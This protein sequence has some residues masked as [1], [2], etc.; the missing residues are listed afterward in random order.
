MSQG[1]LHLTT[2][3]QGGAGRAITALACAQQR[4]GRP[5]TVVTSR[6]GV[7][8]YGNYSEYLDGLIA[9]GVTL[10]CCDSLFNRDEP[11]NRRVLSFLLERLPLD[12]L[13]VIHAHAATP[14]TIGRWLAAASPRPIPVVQTQHG[15]G[16]SKSPEQASADIVILGTL[17]RIVATSN[18]TRDLLVSFGIKSRTIEVIPC[19]LPS[20]AAA[21]CP[22]EALQLVA[23]LRRG[24]GAV[25]GCIGSVTENKNQRLV[26]D[27]LCRLPDLDVAAVFIGEGGSALA[28]HANQAG[29][30]HRVHALGYRPDASRW[31]P[32]FDLLV[33]PSRSEGQGLVVLEAFRA[34]VP[35]VASDIPPLAQV[36]AH[37][38]NGFLFQP[39][40][41]EA[42]AAAIR[43]VL[44]LSTAGR[45]VI[46]TRAR[47]TF[48]RDYTLDRMIARHD[49][50]YRRVRAAVAPPFRP[51][52]DRG[53]PGT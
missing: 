4:S 20:A 16:T 28:D 26:V 51:G 32:S 5:V 14:A 8:G 17:D 34:G 44:A 50:L 38:S 6:T 19:G 13:D 29:V 24:G 48:L 10:H 33:Q 1:V 12:E 25:I 35:V 39:D 27:A 46:V 36:V 9:G 18:A 11:L 52:P 2:F 3:L 47:E 31:L 7:P 22:S 15:W 40:D 53:R 30:G 42:L 23:S 21:P 45:E 41:A 43:D 37:G 49:S